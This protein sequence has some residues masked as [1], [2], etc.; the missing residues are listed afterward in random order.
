MDREKRWIGCLQSFAMIL[1]QGIFLPSHLLR[2]LRLSRKY[3]LWSGI[4]GPKD[5]SIC[6]LKRYSQI[7][8]S[9]DCANW[10]SHQNFMRL[11]LLIQLTGYCLFVCL[12]GSS[13]NLYLIF[14]ISKVE[15]FYFFKK[16]SWQL[17][18]NVV[19]Q[20][21]NKVIQIYIC[22]Y[23]LFSRSLTHIG[24]YRILSRVPLCY[25]A[26]PCWL[27]ILYMVVCICQS[28]TPNL[29]P[30]H[31]FPLVTVSL[32]LKSVSLFLFCK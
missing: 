10:H 9:T 22:M 24:Y 7:V 15:L 1:L 5:I 16:T 25:I 12:S 21:S 19:F 13:F 23:S 8:L 30:P 6:D 18:Y 20:V 17:I 11:S 2:H 27:S 32:F 31:V 14:L 29:S 28:Q 4:V 3:I 26:G